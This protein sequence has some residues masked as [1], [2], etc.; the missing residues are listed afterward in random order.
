MAKR[1]SN[2]TDLLVLK[3]KDKHQVP[4][5]PPHT[6]RDKAGATALHVAGRHGNLAMVQWLVELGMDLR[7]KAGNGATAAHDAA[8]TGNLPCL[9]CLIY[10]CP[11]LKT[12]AMDRDNGEQP[13]RRRPPNIFIIDCMRAYVCGGGGGEGFFL[14]LL[15]RF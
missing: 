7:V 6:I 11:E 12:M 4:D 14:A 1:P 10:H 5:A 8:A 15:L 3:Y 9:Q 2:I 13:H